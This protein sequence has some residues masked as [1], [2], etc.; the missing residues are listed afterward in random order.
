[1]RRAFVTANFDLGLVIL[2]IVRTGSKQKIE[3]HEIST[4]GLALDGSL[5][6]V[7]GGQAH[8]IPSGGWKSFEV[9]RP[10]FH[11]KH[12]PGARTGRGKTGHQSKH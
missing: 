3:T 11:F 2:T 1:M 12:V 10:G 4:V 7:A 5:Q 8:S 6:F 9:T